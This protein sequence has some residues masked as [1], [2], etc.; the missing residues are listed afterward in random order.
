MPLLPYRT[1]VI[2]S[3]LSIDDARARLQDMTGPSKIVRFSSPSRPFE[4]VVSGSNEVDIR[5]AIMH[6]NS[7]VPQIHGRLEAQPTGCRLNATMSLHPFVQV[8]IIV[9]IGFAF[10]YGI[11]GDLIPMSLIM[12]GILWAMA[13]AFFTVEAN[14]AVERLTDALERRTEP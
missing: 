3:P 11:S 12:I 13:S 2:N 1:L 5:R 8:F 14:I 7:F 10:Y 9:W 4:G 6:R